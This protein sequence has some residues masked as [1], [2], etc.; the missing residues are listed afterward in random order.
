M[1]TS[2]SVKGL[3]VCIVTEFKGGVG[4]YARNLIEG[5]K[6]FQIEPL[7]ITG[8]SDRASNFMVIPVR[9]FEGRGRWLPQ[10]Y[11]FSRALKELQHPVDIVHFTDARYSIFTAKK[12]YALLGTMNDYF[13]AITSWFNGAGTFNI[14]QDWKRRHVYYNTVRSLEKRALNRLDAVI[15]ISHEVANFLSARYKIS[16]HKLNVVHYGLTFPDIPIQRKDAPGPTIL[17][18]GGNFQRKGLHTLVDAAELIRSRFP[19]VQFRVLGKSPDEALMKNLCRSKGLM[20]A[21]H[22][23]GNVS[24]SALFEE[25]ARARLFVMPSFLEAFGIP[26]LE[27]MHCGVPIVAS[28]VKG[29][30][31]FLLDGENCL[32]AEV[33][34][35]R[36]LAHQII[37]LLENHSLKDRLV[38]KG[39]ETVKQFSVRKMTTETLD[40]YQRL[41]KNPSLKRESFSH[42]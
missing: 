1:H 35:S 42:S 16:T 34:N 15:C 18:A 24:Y 19:G 17:F 9:R 3:R 14:Y 4:V 25:Y 31:D 7:I 21:F 10:A 26:Y 29:P 12:K 32:K 22:F 2:P 41:L 36:H 6:S 23:C 5:L 40:V 13:Y 20:D 37:E 11:A 8:D 28:T 39:G 27:A 38:E 30:D 33:G